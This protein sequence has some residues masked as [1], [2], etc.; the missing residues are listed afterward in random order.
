MRLLIAFFLILSVFS[1]KAQNLDWWDALHNYPDAAG[2]DRLDYIVISPGYMGPN[3]L[4]M[5][6]LGNMIIENNISFDIRVENHSGNGDKTSNFLLQFN[7]PIKRDRAFFYV[8]SIPTEKWEVTPETRDER[9]MMGISGTGK[10]TGDINFGVVYKIFDENLEGPFNFG[11]RAHAKTTTGGNIANA[12]YSDASMMYWEGT[13]SKTIA[14]T[15]R[16]SFL[17]KLMLGFYT[18]QTNINGLIN[19]STS[20]QNDAPLYGFGLEY[21]TGKWH[22]DT[23]FTGYYGYQGHRDYPGFLR[24]NMVR[25]IAGGEVSMGYNI[26]LK[27]W[28][29]NTFSV[30]YR[31]N[32]S[33]VLD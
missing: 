4:R 17:A 12:R 33:E 25:E 28:D 3:A 2:P 26:G 9:R 5:P 22:F 16:S 24:F 23:D 11:L 8:N 30:G 10:N 14:K 29:W 27:T 13:F 21:E 20:R 31:I 32:V 1:T 18:W 6:L 19:G 7:F 15:E